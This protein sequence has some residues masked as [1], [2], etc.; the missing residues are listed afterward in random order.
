MRESEEM[1]IWRKVADIYLRDEDT[2][3]LWQD[4]SEA[5]KEIVPNE[6]LRVLNISFLLVLFCWIL[7]L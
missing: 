6:K 7:S 3:N 2:A 1:K 5:G 4:A